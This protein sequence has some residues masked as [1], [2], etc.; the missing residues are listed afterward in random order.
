MRL[1]FDISY[2]IYL[3]HMII[4]NMFVELGM[5][6]EMK[7]LVWALIGSIA[8]GFISWYVVEKRWLERKIDG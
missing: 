8:C 4:I 2:G 6:G 7:Y 3:Y 1:P 5:V